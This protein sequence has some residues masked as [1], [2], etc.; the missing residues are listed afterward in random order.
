MML[1]RSKYITVSALLSAAGIILGY[2]ESFIIIP[3]RVPGFRIGFANIVTVLSL[4]IL[5]PVYSAAVLFIRITASALLF[6]SPVSYIY[7][8]TG[9]IAAYSVMVLLSKHGFSVYGVS[10]AGAAV[11]N[12]GQTCA[13]YFLIG[14]VY[15]FYYLPA[16]VIAGTA[17]GLVIGAVSDII[18]RK[19]AVF[20][21]NNES[22]GNT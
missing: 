13:A 15:V 22:E 20:I 14:S 19:L 21:Y 1:S 4:Y 3:I 10:A 8:L 6:G 2:L 17:A 5:G 9:A 16:L 18:I 12:I 7:S 11:H